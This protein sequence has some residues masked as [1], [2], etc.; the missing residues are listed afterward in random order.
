MR[1]NKRLILVI[2]TMLWFLVVIAQRNVY[3]L[4]PRSDLNAFQVPWWDYLKLHGFHGI[5]TINHDING[6]YGPIWYF[7]I[8][9]FCKL[10]IYS[11][12]SV[13]WCIKMLAAGF[14]ILTAWAV[15]KIV[16]VSVG[17]Q[18]WNDVLAYTL[19][20]FSPVVFGDMLKTNLPD[21]SYF[22]FC[23]L[24]ILMILKKQ[25]WL[26]WIF[27]GVAIAFKA[28]GMYVTPFLAFLY[29]RDFKQ[30]NWLN[31]IGPG[32]M[33]VGMA[34][35]SLPAMV[36]GE[37]PWLAIFGNIAARSGGVIKRD[38]GIWKLINGGPWVW[39][40]NL[41]RIQKEQLYLYG[42]AMIILLFLAIYL[43]IYIIP[44]RSRSVQN[45][46]L[47]YMLVGSPLIFWL[48]LPA[49]H[50]TYF[51]IAGIFAIILVSIQPRLKHWLLVIV[52]DFLVW[53][54]YHG[55]GQLFNQ[56]GCTYLLIGVTI[57]LIYEIV[58]LSNV[59]QYLSDNDFTLGGV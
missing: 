37:K 46:A 2:V 52:I 51:S 42:I 19:V 35:A 13:V 58:R 57:Y 32:F 38:Y 28:M 26:A 12:F 20:L 3:S 30:M 21:S 11:T 50:E 17:R 41:T 56:V 23:A 48:F 36:L 15:A 9:I 1:I 29:L 59:K 25:H 14:T 44:Q 4:S 10:G 49:Q 27:V 54:G 7:I 53:S 6:N 33:L 24:A 39:F 47:L 34:L 8:V 18:V 55:L 45:Q 22:F 31:R 5:L 43:L 16:Q 40:P